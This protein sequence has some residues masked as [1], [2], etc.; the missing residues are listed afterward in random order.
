MYVFSK[1]I[2][3]I[4]IELIENAV[5]SK[6]LDQKIF[7]VSECNEIKNKDKFIQTLRKKHHISPICT[8]LK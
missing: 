7:F 4:Y 6:C 5:K 2:L 8:L 1:T 3:L